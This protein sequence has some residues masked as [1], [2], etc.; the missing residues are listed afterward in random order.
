ML[1][2]FN[3][4]S[5]FP[6]GSA[7]PV[8]PYVRTP[9]GGRV[10]L[11]VCACTR[12]GGVPQLLVTAPSRQ[13]TA[14]FTD[15]AADWGPR[16]AQP[17]HPASWQTMNAVD[18]PRQQQRGYGPYGWSQPPHME[19]DAAQSQGYPSSHGYPPAVRQPSPTWSR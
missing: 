8:C 2:L 9:V 17:N 5:I 11:C 15:A 1:S 16:G 18:H 13:D 6:G 7:D 3:F 4:S 19:F 12:Q 14:E 10:R